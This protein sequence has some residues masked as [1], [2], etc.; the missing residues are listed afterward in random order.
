[1]GRT[2]ASKDES[3]Q[4]SDGT[5][6]KRRTRPDEPDVKIRERFAKI[7]EDEHGNRFGLKV[8]TGNLKNRAIAST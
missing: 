6:K 1:M 7:D 4:L 5:L 2:L 8:G 3:S